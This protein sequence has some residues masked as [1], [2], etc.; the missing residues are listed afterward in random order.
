MCI[1]P[2][3][4]FVK[5]PTNGPGKGERQQIYNRTRI[6][7]EKVVPKRIEVK[8]ES[9]K[10]GKGSEMYGVCVSSKKRLKK[11]LDV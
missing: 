9:V 10:V 2:A 5:C 1:D 7:S 11:G 4:F 8:K 6:Q 3:H